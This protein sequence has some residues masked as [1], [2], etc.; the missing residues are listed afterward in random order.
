MP[1]VRQSASIGRKLQD[2]VRGRGGGVRTDTQ[3]L[4]CPEGRGVPLVWDLP[5]RVLLR[6]SPGLS[7]DPPTFIRASCPWK[8]KQIGKKKMAGGEE[9]LIRAMTDK[10][11]LGVSQHYAGIPADP[12]TC[13][14]THTG[15][16]HHFCEEVIFFVSTHRPFIC[17]SISVFT[18]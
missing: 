15:T 9:Q 1:G 13:T 16:H 3:V 12:C 17:T 14:E 8:G 5:L 10:P 7:K 11:C 6:R 4:A 2:V 18:V